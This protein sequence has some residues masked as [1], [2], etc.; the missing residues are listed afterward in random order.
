MAADGGCSFLLASARD[1]EVLFDNFV[2]FGWA[3]HYCISVQDFE[4]HYRRRCNG[5]VT[6]WSNWV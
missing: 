3:L 5:S 6:I 1:I 2:V 4:N